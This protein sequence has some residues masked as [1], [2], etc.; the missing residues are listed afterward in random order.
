M[1]EII[2]TVSSAIAALRPLPD[3]GVSVRVAT[4]EDL[5]FI[6]ELQKKCREQLGFMFLSAIRGKIERGEILIA[7]ER[8]TAD[9]TDSTDKS[10]HLNS[11]VPSV[12]SVVTTPVGYCISVDR[13]S[14]HDDVGIIYQMNVVPGR[15]RSFVAATLLKAMFDRAAYGCKLFCCWCAQDLPANR[16]WEAMGFVP[17]AFRAGSE[18]KSVRR[19][20]RQARVHI[21]WQK[22]IRANDVTTPWWFPS[23]TEG[24]AMRADRIAL[25]IPP[26]KHWSD[27][28][29]IIIPQATEASRQLPDVKE[30]RPRTVGKVPVPSEGPVRHGPK[31]FRAPSA[32]PVIE[33]VPEPVAE[34]IAEKPKREKKP[35]AKADPKLVAAARE[36]RDRWL[37]HVN[38]GGDGAMLIEDAGKYD[39]TRVLPAVSA[40]ERP[41]MSALMELKALPDAA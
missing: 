25:P 34:P 11:S 37:E 32:K 10:G 39:V 1:N 7:E 12:K 35:K 21:F 2:Q 41:A 27:E 22:R 9:D 6:D 13:Y 28:M 33:S 16:F 19:G 18:K 30:K 17:L 14:K 23:K 40:V 4:M 29:P 26:G 36:L 8:L 38:S 20:S 3:A 5:T 24:G 15:Q 31:Q